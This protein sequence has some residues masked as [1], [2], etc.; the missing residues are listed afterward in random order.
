M[1]KTIVRSEGMMCHMCESHVNNAVKKNFKVK[2]VESSHES[3]ETEII[4][5]DVPDEAKLREVIEA[6]GYKVLS[7]SN[8]NVEKKGFFRKK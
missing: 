1:I 6:E 8:E 2:S 7:V 3:G 4:S 5:V